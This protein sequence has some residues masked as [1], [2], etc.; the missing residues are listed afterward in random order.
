MISS[1]ELPRS[2]IPSSHGEVLCQNLCKV[3]LN[4]RL[5][6]PAGWI[7]AHLRLASHSL[8]RDGID[9]SAIYLQY[10]KKSCYGDATLLQEKLTFHFLHFLFRV[11]YVQSMQ[12]SI[13][14]HDP[15]V[16]TCVNV[17]TCICMLFVCLCANHQL[18][19]LYPFTVIS[20]TIYSIVSMTF[21]YN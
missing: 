3:Y 11:I 10:T 20:S 13:G 6:R 15:Y 17:Y 14:S 1:S 4:I 16:H 18:C 9:Y 2:I 5:V 21:S 7:I 19:E 12:I 8:L